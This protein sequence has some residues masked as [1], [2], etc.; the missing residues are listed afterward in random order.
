MS[1]LK[2]LFAPILSKSAQEVKKYI[3]EHE[4]GSYTL[5]DVRQ[6]NEYEEAHI[7]GSKLIPLPQLG[8]ALSEIDPKKP[9]IVY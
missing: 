4:E 7:P 9:V 5:L 2:S 1:L 8:D 6:P 3:D